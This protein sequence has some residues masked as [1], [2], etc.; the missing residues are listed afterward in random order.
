M[1]FLNY[2][3]LK[4]FSLAKQEF[5]KKLRGSVIIIKL[6]PVVVRVATEKVKHNLNFHKSKL[7]KIHNSLSF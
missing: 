7:Y 2:K 5:C 1:E 6:F 4:R 3:L